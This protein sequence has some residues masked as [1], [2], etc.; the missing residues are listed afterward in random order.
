MEG[1]RHYQKKTRRLSQGLNWL[2]HV[3]AHF[4]RQWED[5]KDMSTL[6]NEKSWEVSLSTEPQTST[7]LKSWLA[8]QC[9]FKHPSEAVPRANL[10]RF[11]QW[12]QRPVW[13]SDPSSGTWPSF[14]YPLRH[15]IAWKW[16]ESNVGGCKTQCSLEILPRY[17][18]IPALLYHQFTFCFKSN[19]SEY[20]SN[21]SVCVVLD[22]S[23][24]TQLTMESSPLQGLQYLAD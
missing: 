3:F 23:W 2:L 16:W 10:L 20:F 21:L 15:K 13:I 19:S 12:G 7:L 4:Q 11:V 9:R 17:K 24:R 1:Q 22:Y 5:S 6:P 14:I 8:L 18:Q